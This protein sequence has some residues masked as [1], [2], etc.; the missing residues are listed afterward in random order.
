MLLH[1]N[2]IACM[3][4]QVLMVMGSND[5]PPERQVE[6][7]RGMIGP[8]MELPAGI[9]PSDAMSSM[10]NYAVEQMGGGDFYLAD[11]RAQNAQALELVPL[12]NELIDQEEDRLYGALK[13]AAAGNIIDMTFG[14]EF[15]VEGSLRR[16]MQEG[17]SVMDYDLFTEKLHACDSLVYLLDNAGEIV[18]DRLLMERIQD[19]RTS[20]G[21]PPIEITAVVK[22]G[23]ALNDALMEDAQFAGLPG[24]CHVVS[25][26]INYLGVPV[27]LARPEIGEL[28]ERAPLI[29]AKGQGNYET[30]EGEHGL[31]GKLFH[32]LKVKCVHVENLI[33]APMGSVIFQLK[34]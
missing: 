20:R 25:T 32:L 33:G 2:C 17:F 1:N 22:G 4:K 11:K 21:L 6:I 18:F 34:R 30:L 24:L 27:P 12:V 15:D 9:N 19:W 13:A 8:L 23:P 29:I 5:I 28:L 10:V 26:G 16:C 7:M 31:C 14:T 3:M